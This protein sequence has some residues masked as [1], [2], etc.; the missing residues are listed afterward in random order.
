MTSSINLRVGCDLF[1]DLKLYRIPI[2]FQNQLKTE[3]PNVEVIEVNTTSA[4]QINL[5]TIDIYWGNRITEE[6]IKKLTGIQW[7]HFGSVGVNQAIAQD[8]KQRHIAVTNSKGVMT[9]AV[10]ST[11]LA[12]IFSLARGF[13]HAWNLRLHNNLDR[14]SFDV[15]FDSIQD[16]I[17]QSCLIVGLGEIGQKLSE[18][19]ASIGINVYAVKN[20]ISSYPQWIKKVYPLSKLNDAVSDVDYVI[21]LLPL[22]DSTKGIFNSSIFAAMKRNAFFINVG[23]GD[24]VNEDDLIHAIRIKQIAGAGLD[25]FSKDSYISP[26]IPLCRESPLLKE[27]NIILTP[28]VAGLTTKY[29]KA[30]CDLFF[31]NLR[32]FLKGKPLINYVDISN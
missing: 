14:K 18:I 10:V 21:N 16:V 28:H 19:C 29:W 31:E 17:G 13:H 3:F 6:L 24:T 9:D 32:L 11:V 4:N 12:F 22:V 7:I 30:E 27:E 8:V 1:L 15:F 5:E 20:N 26:G 23:R 2:V 25:V